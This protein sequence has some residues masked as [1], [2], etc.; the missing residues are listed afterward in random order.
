[1]ADRY[2]VNDERSRHIIGSIDDID[3]WGLLD[4]ETNVGVEYNEIE[5]EPITE[6]EERLKRLKQTAFLF[7][8]IRE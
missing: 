7:A 4:H 5:A 3:E 2:D 8:D 1:M 6:G